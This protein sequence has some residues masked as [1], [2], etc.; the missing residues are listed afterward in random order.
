MVDEQQ[1]LNLDDKPKRQR[2]KMSEMV[3]LMASMQRRND[4][5]MQM[6]RA[7]PAPLPAA[8]AN[9]LVPPVPR[10]SLP[11]PP[12]PPTPPATAQVATRYK[13]PLG[14]H[15]RSKRELKQ[16]GYIGSQVPKDLVERFHAACAKE[17]LALY[18]GLVRALE[19]WIEFQ[20]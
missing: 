7:A 8:V 2:V 5:L 19:T 14:T 4:E 18:Q 11:T 1:E 10:T 13:P 12:T 15:R 9:V 17:N 6:L 20:S 16:T 3:E